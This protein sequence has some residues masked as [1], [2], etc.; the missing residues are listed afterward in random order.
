MDL[1]PQHSDP[2][3]LYLEGEYWGIYMIREKKNEDLFERHYGVDGD[4]VVT[5]AAA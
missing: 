3:I 5:L 2:V 1:G 4:T